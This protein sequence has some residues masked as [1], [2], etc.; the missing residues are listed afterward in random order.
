MLCLDKSMLFVD[1]T[2]DSSEVGGIKGW[3]HRHILDPGESGLT[4]DS[5]NYSVR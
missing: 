3:Q 4:V 5:R 1:V 2:Y